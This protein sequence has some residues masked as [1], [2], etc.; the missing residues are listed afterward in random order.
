MTISDNSYLDL[1]FNLT[2]TSTNDVTVLIT[3]DT[4]KQSIRNL[5]LTHREENTKYE[6]QYMG[7]RL[8]HL[9]S[10]KAT[11]FTALQIRDEVI[12]TLTNYEPRIKTHRVLVEFNAEQHYFIIEIF[13]KIIS[14]NLNQSLTINLSA[15][16]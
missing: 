13:Y 8:N 7:S 2:K 11:R 3:E 16:Q 14:L 10:E 9:L 12:T 15:V 4:I 5:L 6:L 1:D